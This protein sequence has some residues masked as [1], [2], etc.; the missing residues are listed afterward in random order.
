[1]PILGIFTILINNIIGVT[2]IKLIIM[3]T[4][5]VVINMKLIVNLVDTN[6]EPLQIVQ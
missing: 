6:I 2:D 1:M 4:E 5:L 3:N